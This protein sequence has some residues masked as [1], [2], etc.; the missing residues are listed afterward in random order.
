[1]YQNHS[2]RFARLLPMIHQRTKDLYFLAL[3]KATLPNYWLHRARRRKSGPLH[4]HLGCGPKYLPGFLNIDANPRRKVDL[5]LDVRCGLPF[6]SGSVDSIYTTHMLE[7]LYSDELERLLKECRRVL[8]PAGGM[9]IIVPNLTSAIRAFQSN[10]PEWFGSYPQNFTSLGGRF[11][12]FIFCA[13][14]HRTAFDFTY[15]DEILRGAGFARVTASGEG[16]SMVYGEQVPRYEAA[17]NGD[18][19]HSLYV[20]AFP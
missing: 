12:N 16:Q 15:F 20:E 1:V 6:K 13:G 14:Q 7:H 8:R 9:R 19:P 17:V 2:F 10:S 4:L 18:L 3:S 11:S 5:W